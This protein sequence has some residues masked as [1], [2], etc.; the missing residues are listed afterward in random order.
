MNAREASVQFSLER[1]ADV[2]AQN[3]EKSSSVIYRRS[4]PSKGEQRLD[5]QAPDT[6]INQVLWGDENEN[7]K[8]GRG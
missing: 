2:S 8:R 3:F 6:Y 7:D 5:A 1:A 4:S